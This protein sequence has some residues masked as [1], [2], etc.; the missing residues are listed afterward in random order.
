MGAKKGKKRSIATGLGLGAAASLLAA[1]NADAAQQ[2]ADL[3]ASDS[4][5]GLLLTLLFPALGWVGF[6]MFQPVRSHDL[7][8]AKKPA[9][10]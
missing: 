4:R 8:A 5:A 1:Q 3:A 9:V 10:N 2:I 7:G 6:N